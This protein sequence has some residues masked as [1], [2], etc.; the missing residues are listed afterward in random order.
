MRNPLS[1]TIVQIPPSG[2]RK[3]FDIVSE[4]KDAISLGVG[5]PDFDTP[6]HIREEGIYS[7]E[8]GR[9]FY[10]SNAG[11][12][13]LKV[14]IC[15]YLKRKCSLT[16]NPDTEV[17]VTVG[18]SEA[19]DIALRAMLD[20]ADEVLIPQ[21]SYVS[22]VPCTILAGGT[23][24]IIELEEKDQFKL[25]PEK[26]LEKITP[27]T[28]VLV[29][30]FP[31]NPTGAIME[32]EELEKIAE[33]VVEK[34]LFVISDEIYCELT[35]KGNHVSIAS[36]PG[37]QE[38]TVLINGF[39]KSYA[40]TGWRLGYAAA[41]EVI[42]K[43]MLKIHQF[44]I[45]C[46]PTTSQYAAVSALKNGDEDVKNMRESYNQRRRFLV[47][48]FREMGLDCFEPFGA[49]YVFPSIK[50]FGMSSDEFCMELLKQ[51]KVAVVPG[52]AFGAS[53]EGFIRVSYAYSLKNLKEALGRIEKFVNR[54]DG[55][56]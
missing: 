55:K 22:Y 3:F 41:P 14:E 2:I 45:M 19:I 46:A 37:M 52:T 27:K 18:G 30:P 15:N 6:W 13:D 49:F 48:A 51:E 23:P 7:L 28:K 53:G 56:A 12:R 10:T 33:I 42:L 17:M 38:R 35:Y 50:R 1:E 32:K 21:P 36:F 24:V 47:N 16:Y 25:T 26:L 29:I 39:S 8:K 31:N 40:M 11:L 4:M 43:Q 44:A 34:D 9:T 5:E 54:L 20:P